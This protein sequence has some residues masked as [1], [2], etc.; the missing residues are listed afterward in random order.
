[1]LAVNIK[2]NKER[3]DT[4]STFS[5]LPIS[6]EVQLDSE[7]DKLL[8]RLSPGSS[9]GERQIAAKKIG[10]MRRSEALPTLLA[11][12]PVDPFWMVRCSIIQALEMIGDPVAIPILQ[13]VAESD[14]FLA[15]RTYAKKAVER[16][17]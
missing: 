6:I 14:G 13:D 15:V 11:A 7:L 8:A 4:L 12:L 17:S 2:Q 16:L 3:V 10:Q 5:T 9:W 1:M